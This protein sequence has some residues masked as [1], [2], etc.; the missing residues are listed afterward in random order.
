MIPILNLNSILTKVG[1]TIYTL[2]C[3]KCFNRL[4]FSLEELVLTDSRKKNIL[5]STNRPS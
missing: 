1:W 4:T 3:F 2:Q 5:D